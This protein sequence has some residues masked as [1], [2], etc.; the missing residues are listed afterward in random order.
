[1]YI[2][3]NQQLLK[4][5]AS[6][7]DNYGLDVASDSSNA[8]PLEATED[9]RSSRM[10]AS[11]SSRVNSCSSLCQVFMSLGNSINNEKKAGYDGN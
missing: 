2:S 3:S 1:M 4:K 6:G 9:R 7:T 8:H 11:S 10:P 5:D